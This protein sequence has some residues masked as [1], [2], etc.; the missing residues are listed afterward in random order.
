[1]PQDCLFP[2]HTCP[3][4]ILLSQGERKGLSHRELMGW[5][6]QASGAGP[7][8]HGELRLRCPRHPLEAMSQPLLLGNNSQYYILPRAVI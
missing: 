8:V 1:M 4:E 2:P 6:A 3:T 5:E 7:R